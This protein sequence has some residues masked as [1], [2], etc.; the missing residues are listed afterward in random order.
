M[1]VKLFTYITYITITYI[2][3][4][5]YYHYHS[6]IS[7][8]TITKVLYYHY[9]S[10]QEIL[11]LLKHPALVLESQSVDSQSPLVPQTLEQM[12]DGCTKDK[13]IKVRATDAKSINV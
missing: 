7:Y 3:Y 1:P 9:H 6:Y 5:T 12:K 8:I 11:A 10:S 2:N 4:I 13:T